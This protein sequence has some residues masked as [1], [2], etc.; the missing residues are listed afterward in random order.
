[1]KTSFF[2]QILRRFQVR[3]R[4]AGGFLLILLLAGLVSPIILS[5]LNSLVNQ[6]EQFT[7]VDTQV[8]RLLLLT[9]RRV[10]N[11]QLN[12]NRFI[13]DYVPSPYEAL[14]D[15]DQAISGLQEA[16]SI[17][18]DPGE[19][20][21][22]SIIIQSLEDYKNQITALQEALR[23]GDNA[24]ATRLESRL[25]KSGNDIGIRLELLVNENVKR[26]TAT[27]E[28]V[29]NN[30]Q[31]GVQLGVLFIVIGVGL[32]VLLSILVTLSI[33]RPLAE[34]YAGTDAFQKGEMILINEAGADEFTNLAQSF[35]ALTRQIRELIT[36]LEAR[37]AERT[38]A[39]TTVAEI[40]TTASTILNLDKL[41][42]EIV[43]LSKERF[44]L[45]HSHIY[46]LDE[47]GEN[48][49]LTAGAGEAGQKMVLQGRS[50]PL[51][52]EQSLVARA[53]R[54]RKGVTVNDVT[55]APD[56]LPNPLLPD[57]RSELAVPMLIGEQVIG[58]FD[59]QSDV[60]GRFTD[61]DIA[62]QTA[63]ASQVAAA[64]QNARLYAR[65][66]TAV[67]E[68]QILVNYAP[69]AIVVVDLETGLFIEPNGNAEK[70]YGLSHDE[71]IKVGPAQM[72]PPR[73]PDG[74]D[75]TE[76]AMEKIDEAMQGQAPVFDW[77]LRNAQGQDILC[78]VRLV[79]LPGAHPRVR[80]S[81]TDITERKRLEELTIQ[82]A[83]YQET[84]NLITQ[85]IQSA[86]TI[87]S[88][89]QVAAREL[90]HAL[91]MKPTHVAL[92]TAA[93]K[94]GADDVSI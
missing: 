81:V 18:T 5:N 4:V 22:I 54:E 82:R 32:A 53:A 79:R 55:Q 62:V 13:Q 43:E 85:R 89:L 16:R 37:V 45:Y 9:S 67:Q 38:K 68:A 39:L 86:S 21:T 20:E 49:V 69:E 87:E 60:I 29:L 47:S 15:I 17:A 19:V 27:N 33:T 36:D 72:S 6:L 10:A 52:R 92:D 40:G 42:Q 73:Q 46:L 83:H 24:E 8:E 35:N 75:S 44:N 78:E 59:V 48:L 3:T 56:F 23:A 90:G 1:M 30:A 41:M 66:E 88:A 50:I 51:E 25:Q 7:N 91:G 70:L 77:M 74:R 93:W 71:L 14:D 58:V 76:K 61:A 80:A 84:I 26:V 57:T 65:I 34:L 2:D 94:Q 64:V 63:L 28:T 31:R 11:S 12:L